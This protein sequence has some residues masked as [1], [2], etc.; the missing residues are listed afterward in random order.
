M[1]PRNVSS[2]V[3]DG[4]LFPLTGEDGRCN[5]CSPTFVERGHRERGG[6]DRYRSRYD[7]RDRDRERDRYGPR[8]DER[9]DR[10][11]GDRHREHDDRPRRHHDEDRHRDRR[12]GR[13][14][15]P[16]R[17]PRH[18]RD[19]GA[20]SGRGRRR[21]RD[22][23][24]ER[25][26]PTPEGALPLSQRKRKATGWDV[27]APGYE[28]YTAQQAKQT[29]MSYRTQ[30]PNTTISSDSFKGLFPLPGANRTQVAPILAHPGL[31][32][33]MPVQAFG[34]GMGNNP[35]LARQSRR[36]YIGSITPDVNEHN[37]AEF[38]N[39]K[40]RELGIGTAIGGKELPVVQVQLNYEKNY[41]FVEV[42]S[43]IT[44]RIH[45]TSFLL[46]SVLPKM[47]RR[48]WRSTESFSSTAL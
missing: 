6:E 11:R 9:R 19:D 2:P 26:S 38:F 18:E 42:C 22:G 33:P 3:R 7:D 24:P 30:A 17:P 40:M 23:T 10:E 35:N 48:R 31:P 15:G 14:D 5:V 39:D 45:F 25:R 43:S 32:M 29:G 44:L 8:R 4:Q 37:L 1:T 20:P 36:L 27:H 41:A 13:E 28:Q 47:Q 21:D 16:P 34:M 46:S 12:G